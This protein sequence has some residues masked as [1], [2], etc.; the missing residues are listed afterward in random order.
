MKRMIL[1]LPYVLLSG[2]ALA[3]GGSEHAT[4]GWNADPF[5]L[6]PLALAAALYG[7]GLV[8]LGR[9]A[10]AWRGVDRVQAALFAAGLS[11]AAVLLLSPL[12]AVAERKLSA[13]MIQHFGLMLAAAPL[14]VL[15]E[16]GLAFL[17]ALPRHAR[18]RI[19]A[20]GHSPVG[21]LW[22]R[23][24]HPLGAWC[25]YFLALWLWHAPPLHEAALRSDTIHTL[26]HLS[27]VGA[28]LLFWTAVL[29]GPRG[30]G[31]ATAFLA[32]F[33]TAVHSCA[34]AALITTS[35][36]L[37][38]PA[39]GADSA[40]LHDQ[41]LAGLIMWGPCCAVLIGS[42]IA[43]L[44]RLLDDLARRADAGRPS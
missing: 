13:H 22:R 34:L 17:W 4:A 44:A 21:G 2:P 5:V 43:L 19:G 36:V 23:L 31:R 12:D 40:A 6:L 3:H 7:L 15:G 33:T 35:S 20:L 28:A 14:L 10:G 16:P 11:L 27:F 25:V 32:I 30:E 8:R 39:Y 9:A 18:G 29:N 42:A 24:T 41:Q 38:Y 1:P 26:Q 37:W